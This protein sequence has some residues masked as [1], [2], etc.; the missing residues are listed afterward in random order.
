MQGP[1]CTLPLISATS[2]DRGREYR[3]YHQS[4]ADALRS[5][6]IVRGSLIIDGPLVTNLTISG[7]Q[8][9]QFGG[10]T[11]TTSDN[12]LSISAPDLR[13]I[14]DNFT[15]IAL[16]AL[17][18]LNLPSWSPE[19]TG[20]IWQSCPNLSEISLNSSTPN[21]FGNIQIS[22]TGFSSFS[23]LRFAISFVTSHSI[24]IQIKNN[25]HARELNFSGLTATSASIEILNNHPE[26][27]VSFPDLWTCYNLTIKD[28]QQIDIPS[29]ENVTGTVTLSNING[30]YFEAP[31]LKNIGGLTMSN[32]SWLGFRA[33]LLQLIDGDFIFENNS[34]LYRLYMDSLASMC[35]MYAFENRS[36]IIMG[37]AAL[38]EVNLPQLREADQDILI[39][40]NLNKYVSPTHKSCSVS[41]RAIK[42]YQCRG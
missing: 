24:D 33:P 27:V 17:K 22:D 12:L 13:R 23:F 36:L 41:D 15:L 7:V 28:A 25:I 21:A 30:N 34:R 10:L 29:L 4:D 3:I 11:A 19:F 39:S 35:A 18:T 20:L 26:A 40:G 38:R 14:F 2:L 31:L 1:E 37:N 8:E 6:T 16:P 5:C 32:N 42:V 9:I